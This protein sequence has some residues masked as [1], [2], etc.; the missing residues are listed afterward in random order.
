MPGFLAAFYS[1]GATCLLTWEEIITLTSDEM[2]SRLQNPNRLTQVTSFEA[3][4]QISRS[5]L[6]SQFLPYHGK[7]AVVL[8][9]TEKTM[10]LN[11]HHWLK[12]MLQD[13]FDSAQQL[14]DWLIDW[15]ITTGNNAFPGENPSYWVTSYNLRVFKYAFISAM[16]ILTILLG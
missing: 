8:P 1:G 2:R 9:H 6:W 5:S 7:Q 16:N 4:D 12:K 11:H 3:V 14:F 10:Q 13:L 15:L